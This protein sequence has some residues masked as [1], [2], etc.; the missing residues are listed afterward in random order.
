[1]SHNTHPQSELSSA[2]SR[3]STEPLLLVPQGKAPLYA[4]F[5]GA[6][7]LAIGS[8]AFYSYGDLLPGEASRSSDVTRDAAAF[9]IPAD[10]AHGTFTVLPSNFQQSPG[11]VLVQLKMPEAEK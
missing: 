4:A 6:L 10:K 8:V 1:M 2:A 9:T 5:A 3:V 11:S 7:A